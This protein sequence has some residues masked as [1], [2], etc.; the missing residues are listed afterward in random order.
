MEVAWEGGL[1][2]GREHVR[3]EVAASSHA[4]AASRPGARPESGSGE[5]ERMPAGEREESEWVCPFLSAGVTGWM[6]VGGHG[7]L[8]RSC[9]GPSGRDGRP[10]S[11]NIVLI[12]PILELNVPIR[13]TIILPND[14]LGGTRII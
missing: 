4:C 11:I 3:A 7:R 6:G 5:R 9:A 14:V 10:H 12:S 1:E 13:H 2:G 8:S